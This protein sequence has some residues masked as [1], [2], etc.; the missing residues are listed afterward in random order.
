MPKLKASAP[1]TVQNAAE[2]VPVRV[3]KTVGETK[4]QKHTRRVYRIRRGGCHISRPHNKRIHDKIQ[5]RCHSGMESI[6][7]GKPK[8]RMFTPSCQPLSVED[9]EA[10]EPFTWSRGDRIFRAK[11]KR[12]FDL[13]CSPL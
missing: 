9:G 11:T 10:S 5:K 4:V 12:F 1:E 3:V 2:P 8:A 13:N 6:P 7:Q